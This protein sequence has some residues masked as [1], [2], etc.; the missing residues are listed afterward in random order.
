MAI[1]CEP[2]AFEVLMRRIFNTANIP[3]IMNKV[4]IILILAIIAPSLA[5]CVSEV[6][7]VKGCTD[8]D[9]TNY[10]V[11]AT[12]ND[13]SCEFADSDGD[14][15]LNHIEVA[16]CTDENATNYNPK[17]TD[18]DGSC[19]FADSDGDGVFD[20]LEV[21]GCTDVNA[22]NYNPNATDSDRS[23][24]YEEEC[25]EQQYWH[26]ISADYPYPGLACQIPGPTKTAAITFIVYKDND[27]VEYISNESSILIGLELINSLYNPFGI[28]LVIG[29]IVYVDEA[30]PEA[31]PNEDGEY[32]NTVSISELG[33]GFT[34]NY[35]NTNVNIVMTTDGWGAYALFPWYNQNYYAA[36]VKAS[37]FESS[38]IPA[39][40]LGHFFGLYH[41]HAYSLDPNAD[42]NLE[43]ATQ[44]SD[45]WVIPT[46]Q[47]Y[48]TGDFICGTPYDC[49]DDCEQAIGCSAAF[50]Y[51]EYKPGQASEYENCTAEEHSP[52][53]DNLMSRYSNRS[54]LTHDQGARMRYFLQ[55]MFDIGRLLP[56]EAGN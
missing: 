13:K 47:C 12:I 33:S 3:I 34:D 21:A 10:D 14:G 39:H 30:F 27:G 44:W 35:N 11:N 31:G 49:Y 23:C 56:V 17:A 52:S 9:A 4:V 32:D 42:S 5:G 20:H 48:R 16:G 28:N 41:T 2:A 46:E 50:L 45:D 7:N 26:Q 24:I 25:D 37:S 55:Y 6:P 54:V 8:A 51:M 38:Y 1:P 29:E 22:T 36:F 15:V 18:D 19:E 53:L 40:E 43:N